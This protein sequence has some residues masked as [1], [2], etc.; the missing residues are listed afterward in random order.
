MCARPASSLRCRPY[1]GS[2]ARSCRRTRT[3]DPTTGTFLSPDPIDGTP[4]TPD[5]ANPYDYVGNDPLNFADPLGLCR[6]RDGGLR[7]MPAYEDLAPG[8]YGPPSVTGYEVQPCQG[9]A[10]CLGDPSDVAV[11]YGAAGTSVL[12]DQLRAHGITE[13]PVRNT[14]P[15]QTRPILEPPFSSLSSYGDAAA[16]FS[17][18]TKALGAAGLAIEGGLILNNALGAYDCGGALAAADS[19][20]SDVAV[21]GIATVTATEAAAIAAGACVATGVGATVVWLCGLGGGAVGAFAGTSLGQG[22]VGYLHSEG[23]TRENF[24]NGLRR[25]GL[26]L[27]PTR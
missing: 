22:I 6:M 12:A 3:Y 23:F 15:P 5:E 27:D 24:V 19:V 16:R 8:E 17:T 18:L 9:S 21:A 10:E 1:R 13:I 14:W 25:I 4:G 2:R 7:L 20:A 11:G 26:W